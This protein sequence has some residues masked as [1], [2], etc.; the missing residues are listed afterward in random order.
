MDKKEL[1]C[2]IRARKQEHSPEQLAACSRTVCNALKMHPKVTGADTV[3]LYWSM[4]DEVDTHDLVRL[5][6]RQGKKVLLPKVVSR[7]E[8]TLHPFT[9]DT[10]MA[11]NGMG[12]V[13]PTTPAVP[14]ESLGAGEGMTAIMPGM[15]FTATGE[16]M[17]R[18]R[19]YY[20]RMLKR[21]PHIYKIGI[22]FP[23]QLLDGIPSDEH[24]VRMDEVLAT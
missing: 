7:E 17:G 23:F 3:L 11:Q 14:L 1:R 2:I 24:D 12:I 5:L 21:L 8:M 6:A 19:G 20:D 15:A 10:D 4:A 18:G 16:R 13:E 9:S 22:C